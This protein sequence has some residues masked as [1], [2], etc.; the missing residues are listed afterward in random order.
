[1]I[2]LRRSA[3]I[4][5]ALL[6]A[7]CATV[8]RYEAAGDIR[9]FLVAIRDGERQTFEAHVDRASLKLQ[10]RSRLIAGQAAAHGSQSW[11]AA[12]AVLAGPLVDLG[13]DAFVQPDTFRAVALQLGYAPDR[14]LPNRVEIASA[15][16]PLDDGRV[17]VITKTACTL[18]FKDEGGVWKLIGYEGDLGDLLPRTKAR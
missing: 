15:L 14:P 10:L 2:A 11:Q 3:T 16:R 18:V 4:A 7:A 12:G 1:M 9:A 8:P 5:V 6:V 13:V 17:C